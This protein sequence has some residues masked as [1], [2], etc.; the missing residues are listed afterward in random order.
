MNDMNNKKYLL[1]FLL[2][3]FFTIHADAQ[4]I[5]NNDKKEIKDLLLK[6]N[7]DGSHYLKT[8]LLSQIWVRYTQN[9]PGSTIDGY[10]EGET[11]DI[12]I[13]RLRAQ[14]F[15]KISDKVFIYAQFG[16]NNLSYDSPRKQGLFIHDALAEL[17][18]SPEYCSIGAGLTGWSGLSRY[19]SPAVGSILSLDAPL[20]QQATNDVNDQFLRKYS[21]Y[22]KGKIDRLDYRLA[23]SK[24]LTLANTSAQYSSLQNYSQ[25]SPL[26]TSP[27]YQGYIM[28]QLLDKESDIV[29]YTTGSYLG[30][31]NILTIGCGFI[32][33]KNAVWHRENIKDTVFQ[34]MLLLAADVYFEHTLNKELGNS[35]NGYACYSKYDYGKNYYRNLGVMNTAN[36]NNQ[37]NIVNGAGNA[38][39]VYGTG[40]TMYVQLGYLFPHNL[41]STLGTLQVYSCM[42]Y[43]SYDILH[44]P[45]MMLEGGIN[46]LIDGNR[47]KISFNYQKRPIYSKDILDIYT[48]IDR[49][50]MFTMQYQI[51]I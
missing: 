46:W 28:Y 25:F 6:L 35:I 49:L 42:Q 47:S 48:I 12:G 10:P 2:Y 20:Y 41:L 50:G 37:I 4:G 40:N 26:P 32:S 9:N 30:K 45:M 29:P 19:A 7:E 31:K 38:F 1:T 24:P 5:G 44:I 43:S 23:I 18:I 13:R 11:F 17:E 51:M 3:M 34:N 36:G 22:A 33:Q 39:P 27:Q 15:G 21:V 8:T 14:I 16:Q